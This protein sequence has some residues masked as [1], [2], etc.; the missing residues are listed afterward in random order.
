M[1]ETSSIKRNADGQISLSGGQI[2]TALIITALTG[3]TGFIFVKVINQGERQSATDA[4][5]T[6]LVKSVDEIKQDVRHIGEAVGA[7]K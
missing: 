1:A 7:K 6:Q 4:T 3:A 2:L 5:M